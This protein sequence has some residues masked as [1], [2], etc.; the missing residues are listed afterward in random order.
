[1]WIVITA[2]DIYIPYS[3]LFGNGRYGVSLY[4]FGSSLNTRW[5]D[6]APLKLSSVRTD[7][8]SDPH[9]DSLA[10]KTA[11]VSLDQIL[12]P[13]SLTMFKVPCKDGHT[14]IPTLRSVLCYFMSGGVWGGQLWDANMVFEVGFVASVSHVSCLNLL[15]MKQ[16]PKNSLLADCRCIFIPAHLYVSL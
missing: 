9:S 10:E 2:D 5:Q 11:A 12:V 13:V 16:K 8:Q 3:H 1:M 7:K 4:V 14:H 6:W 15:N